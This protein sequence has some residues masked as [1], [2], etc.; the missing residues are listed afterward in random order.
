VTIGKSTTIAAGT[1]LTKS[2]GEKELVLT[3]VMQDGKANWQKP[4]MSKY[5]N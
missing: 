2:T 1:T 5:N 4:L 3:R